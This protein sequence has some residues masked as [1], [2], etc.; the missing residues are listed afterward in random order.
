MR[1][2]SRKQKIRVGTKELVEYLE[3]TMLRHEV[4]RLLSLLRRH[5]LAKR[6]DIQPQTSGAGRPMTIWELPTAITIEL[7]SKLQERAKVQA[8]NSVSRKR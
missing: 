1:I 5:G 2:T 6:V 4:H 8:K 3:G 7:G